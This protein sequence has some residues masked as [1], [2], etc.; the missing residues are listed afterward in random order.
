[1]GERAEGK[2][3]EGFRFSPRPN[4][5]DEVD[6][7]PWGREAFGQAEAEGKL[8]L[9]SISAVWCH[10]CHVMDET[11]YSDPGVIERINRDFIPVRVDSDKRPDVNRRY[12]QGGWPTTAF[13]IPSGRAVAG[14]TYAPPEQLTSLL[15][16]LSVLY[17]HRKNDIDT[18][19]AA[20]SVEERELAGTVLNRVELDPGTSDEV[21]AA[22]LTAWDRE[23]GGLGDAPKF[24]QPEAIE[25]ALA[26]YFDT[27]DSLLESFA[28]STLDAMQDG[29]IDDKVEGGFFRY[30]TARDWSTPHYEKMLADNAELP[31]LYLI[32]S[33]V[34]RKPAYADTA[35]SSIDYSMHTLMDDEQ[36]GF[37]GSQDADEEYYREDASGRAA[38]EPPAVDRT[39]YTDSSSRMVSTLVLA[40]SVLEDPGLLGIAERVADFIW[41]EGF[42]H[43]GGLCHYFELPEGQPALWG[44]PED[45]VSYLQ[46]LIDLYQATA[47]AR[48]LDRAVEL[49]D[50]M[51]E[52]FIG[53]RGWIGE[54]PGTDGNDP[55]AGT[56]VL[57]DIPADL[58]D[59]R[60][61][62][63]GARALLALDV[64]APGR[65]YDDAAGRALEALAGRYRNYTYFAAGYA[66]AVEIFR[67]GFIEV[68]ISPEAGPE[69][70]KELTSAA[71]SA[72][73]PRKLVRLET[74]E[75]YI[76]TE[77]G[78]TPPPAILCSP[79]SCMPAGS[80]AELVDSLSLLAGAGG[81]AGKG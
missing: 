53:D 65:G 72:Y 58:P 44:Q 12:N 23:Y 8:V 35:R 1:M 7:R 63:A 67:E 54:D 50:V 10:W 24:P 76:P 69:L 26:G 47:D 49:G 6:W 34:L 3:G 36:R 27:G 38:L 28:L 16:R 80:P 32:A 55:G 20:M 62:G 4:R 17:S 68:R 51:L 57:E 31:R 70:R 81:R 19:A 79:G 46:A 75:D 30:A 13:L 5:A 9:L 42:R 43:G 40:S 37:F 52:R 78:T 48:F 56:Q 2:E 33:R 60:V 45:Q 73:H 74:V 14:L 64:L 22:I 59:I 77:D 39:I 61:N 15:D 21:K 25:F 71:V 29:E 66:I 41:R 11:T 18:E